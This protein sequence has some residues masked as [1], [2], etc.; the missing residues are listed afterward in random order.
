MR[1]QKHFTEEQKLQLLKSPYIERV[2]SNHVEYSIEFKQLAVTQYLN[3][4]TP[5]EI[6][7]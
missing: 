5:V 4:K 2:L 7:C 3:G 6:C 1:K